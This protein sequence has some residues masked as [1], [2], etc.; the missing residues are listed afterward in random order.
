MTHPPGAFRPMGRSGGGVT[1]PWLIA[2]AVL[3]VLALVGYSIFSQVNSR[4]IP[5]DLASDVEHFKYGSI[6]SD[7]PD[8][9]GLPD[10]KSVV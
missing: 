4:S 8:G 1:S 3:V 5:E 6:G 10:R 9:N 2:L 7:T